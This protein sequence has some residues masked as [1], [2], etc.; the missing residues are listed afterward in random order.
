MPVV[1]F[2]SRKGGAGKTT[3][4]IILGSELS[5]HISV[6]MIDADPAAR[7]SRWAKRAPLPE[8]ISLIHCAEEDRILD[9]LEN[10]REKSR[11]VLIDTEGLA[12][13]LNTM[14]SLNSNLVIVPMGDEQ[15]DADDAV[16]T[17]RDLR[18][19][20][21]TVGREVKARILFTRVK[22]AVKATFEREL[23]ST[24]RGGVECF[25]T[26]LVARTA[27]ST[28]HNTGGT[29]RQLEGAGRFERAIENAESFVSEVLETFSESGAV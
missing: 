19:D 3:A 11:F 21:R 25:S 17:L 18:N 26:E 6:T 29:L 4:C 5:E 7:L 1:T 9:V 2:A 22:A 8:N 13:R 20:G 12:S 27:Y 14:I 24:M 23:N 10:A 15:Q 16:L 28:L